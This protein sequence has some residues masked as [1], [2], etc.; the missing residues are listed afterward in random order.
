MWFLHSNP[1]TIS[2]GFQVRSVVL[3][4]RIATELV[5]QIIKFAQRA[6]VPA[7]TRV[8]LQTTGL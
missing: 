7:A 1:K 5:K 4:G 3:A 6:K 2:I 8:C